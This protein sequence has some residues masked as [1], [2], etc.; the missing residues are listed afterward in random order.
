[1][2]CGKRGRMW[3]LL[4]VVDLLFLYELVFELYMLVGEM[5]NC[6][7]VYELIVLWLVFFVYCNCEVM[8]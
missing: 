8:C 2:E 6:M 7:S 4:G 1:M 5:C 3:L